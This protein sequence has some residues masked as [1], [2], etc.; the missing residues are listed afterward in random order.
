MPN[1]QSGSP[2]SPRSQLASSHQRP[3]TGQGSSRSL[4]RPRTSPHLP[5]AQL[6]SAH[7]NNNPDHS[8][9]SYA[10]PSRAKAQHGSAIRLPSPALLFD[11]N[12]IDGL[13]IFPRRA[14]SS[15]PTSRDL[16]ASVG[17]GNASTSVL[18][19][20][21]EATLWAKDEAK[22]EPVLEYE[23]EPALEHIDIPSPPSTYS[24]G[25]EHDGNEVRPTS[26]EAPRD[27]IPKKVLAK[28]RG[29]AVEE[30]KPPPHSQDSAFFSFS[31]Q[32]AFQ[33]TLHNPT[34]PPKQRRPQSQ[35][36]YTK[37]FTF[38]IEHVLDRY[39]RIL[40]EA[41][42]QLVRI[43]QDELDENALALFVR[44]Y[45]R[46]QPYWYRV[47]GLSESYG[48]DIDIQDA[49]RQLCS[50]ALIA[51]SKYAA[52][53]GGHVLPLLA[54]EL[55]PTLGAVEVKS[56]CAS[57]VEGKSL[58]RLP[59]N[60][61]LPAL[62][63]ILTDAIS[64]PK[65]KS[66]NLLQTTLSGLSPAQCLAKAILKCAGHS[67]C[68]P[69]NILASLARVHFLFFLEDGHD[70]PNVILADTGKAKFPA[71]VCQPSK[72]IFPS[73]FA[74]D[75]YEDAVAFENKL[76]QELEN[77]E[78]E[79]V[80][81]LGSIAELEVRKFFE[82]EPSSCEGDANG[83]DDR[84]LPSDAQIIGTAKPNARTE[85]QKA[86]AI[87]QLAHPFFRRYTAQWV[88]VRACWHSVH[89]LERLGEH[90]CAVSRLQ[91]LLKTRLMPRRRGRCL[92]RLTI[93]LFKHLHKVE[94]PL[95]IVMNALSDEGQRLNFGDRI[96]L[97]Q[98]A[99]AMH[100]KLALP[101]AQAKVKDLYPTAASRKKAA[102]VE[103]AAMTPKPLADVLQATRAKIAVRKLFG[104]SL[105]VQSHERRQRVDSHE[106]GWHKFVA[107]NSRDSFASGS[108][109]DRSLMGKAVFSSLKGDGTEL[110][111]EE[112]CL[113]WY[114]AKEGWQGV[115][116]E[117]SAIR[118]LFCL[119]LWETVIFKNVEDVFQTPYQ[120]RPLDLMT[121]AFYDSR[122]HEIESRV[123]EVRA[124]NSSQICEETMRLYEKFD[125][126]RA[127]GCAWS[128][129]AKEDFGIIAGGLG[130]RALASCCQNLCQD[131]GYWSGGLPDLTLWKA[132]DSDVDDE[133]VVRYE[134]KLVEVKSA[135]D[136]LSE[137]QRAWLFE[138]GNE[139][140]ACEVCKV[141]E[142]VTPQNAPELEEAELDY[143][144]IEALAVA[145]K[146]K[147]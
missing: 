30:S 85:L 7:I 92:N 77:G 136:S 23:P 14:R 71:Y 69:S 26:P 95:E 142:R 145:A 98:R 134:T 20:K 65:K 96:Q 80:A 111:V 122:K 33:D 123:G 76:D 129:Y 131:Y 115:H 83:D 29:V 50:N 104:K 58:K 119:L 110:S 63:C 121:E 61:L 101:I 66:K 38:V 54:R 113:E 3:D 147:E 47:S 17:S 19:T 21:P 118:F 94:Q 2:D 133:P 60:Q 89:A 70:S 139:E 102:L 18:S 9:T 84:S 64:K 4:K 62:Q 51:S 13:S 49:I 55:L 78:Y 22:M 43:L 114:F 25:D 24:S 116:D 36:Y 93:N 6:A 130:G 53:A 107:E 109:R 87:A 106:D 138:L 46:K 75:D 32:P 39:S 143:I 137:R 100:K 56:V 103:L 8:L 48:N 132:I 141:V 27:T 81:Y 99:I 44:I 72:P 125:G 59:K 15:K 16:S 127:I 35:R 144:A 112:Y 97:A 67:V 52:E 34:K 90:E 105:N 146:E 135:R 124:M 42:V 73:S 128:T 108:V 31:R 117:G 68:I 88:Y 37:A 74:Y 79:E 5:P 82:G 45:R 41:D 57:V 126:T 91:L 11:S 120:D 10:S 40:K 140:A 28:S 86:E 12:A 1:H